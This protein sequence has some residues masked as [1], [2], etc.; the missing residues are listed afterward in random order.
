MDSVGR[1]ELHNFFAFDCD[2]CGA[3]NFIRPI[4]GEISIGN[5]QMEKHLLVTK[6]DH[7]LNVMVTVAPQMV[8]C[9]QCEAVFTTKV[10]GEM[11]QHFEDD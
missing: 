11:E 3:E 2:E 6:G 1:V 4:K 7:D 10:C 9:S 5:G 8:R